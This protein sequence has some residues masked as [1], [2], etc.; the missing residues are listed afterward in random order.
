MNLESEDLE[1]S[2]QW[3]K[4]LI[5][6]KVYIHKDYLCC[7]GN[8]YFFNFGSVMLGLE[9]MQIDMPNEETIYLI[10]HVIASKFSCLC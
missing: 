6:F 2:R 4:D 3:G 1:R 10:F 7:G 8:W 9:R 5:L